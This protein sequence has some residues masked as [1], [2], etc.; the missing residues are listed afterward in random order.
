MVRESLVLSLLLCPFVVHCRISKHAEVCKISYDS[1]IISFEE[2]LATL[3][4]VHDP[5]TLNKQGA[6]TGTQY[7]SAV[8]YI[9]EE[10]KKIARNFINI[11]TEKKVG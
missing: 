4:Q 11:L 6:D 10:Q 9:N 7:R 1:N 5:T 2:L 8:F 3:F